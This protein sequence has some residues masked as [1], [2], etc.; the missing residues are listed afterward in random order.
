MPSGWVGWARWCGLRRSR[1]RRS[2]L[3]MPR[4]LVIMGSGETAPGMLGVH[5]EVF[6]GLP[7]RARCRILDSTFAFQENA[8][9]LVER[10][11]RYFGES[12]GRPIGRIRLAADADALTRER[13]LAAIRD[14]D[15]LFAGPGSPTYALR[16]WD[17]SVAGALAESLAP[18]RSAAL[19]LASAAAATLGDCALPVYEVYKV[20]QEPH[21]NAGLGLM[22]RLLGW[23]CVVVPHY[24]NQEG[25]THDTRYCYLGARRL[26]AIEPELG[27]GFILGVDEHTALLLDLDDRV[28]VV[29]GR[30]A[31]TL[32]VQG[33]EHVLPSGSRLPLEDL[34]ACVA[35]LRRGRPTG[36]TGEAEP[37]SPS[38]PTES[39]ETLPPAPG[40][41]GT[42]L[43]DLSTADLAEI[44]L[45]EL[46][47]T[48]T[49]ERAA[50]IALVDRAAD[51]TLDRG[52]AL[53]A[54]VVDALVRVRTGARADGDWER[55]DEL[56]DVIAAIGVE[57]RDTRD[58][59]TWEWA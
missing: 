37:G 34:D 16:C 27:E 26:A 36:P 41:G 52:H 39:F 44:V 6:A 46:P 54:P 14:S 29:A 32:R 12:L 40:H 2:V 10:I 43:S 5:R 28:A 31:L 11:G 25:G 3:P 49:R 22:D 1:H 19:V 24:D 17:D 45:A 53:A 7:D 20:G 18:G 9:E 38:R 55:S 57:V 59:S 35:D 51:A 58:G 21:W 15:W 23:R 4:L 56:R 47:A 8:D 50:L 13:A 33:R 30:G 48:A 42:D